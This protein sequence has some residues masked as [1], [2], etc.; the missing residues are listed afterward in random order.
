MCFLW[1]Q[2]ALQWTGEIMNTLRLFSVRGP[3]RRVVLKAFDVT[4][5]LTELDCRVEVSHGKFIVEEELEVD[6]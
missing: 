3:C 4:A 6:L 2:S 1:I 5:Q